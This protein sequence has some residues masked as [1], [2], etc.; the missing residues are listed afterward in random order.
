MLICQKCGT[1]N[2]LGRVFCQSCGGKLDLSHMSQD[3][4]VEVMQDKSW[5]ARHWRKIA[6][7]VG[8]LVALLVVLA[9]I[10]TAG[11]LGES[12]TRVGGRRV[13][14]LLRQLGGLRSGQAV[15]ATFDE[16]DVNGYLALV[17]ADRLKDVGRASVDI[18]PGYARLHLQSEWFSFSLF[19]FEL[20]PPKTYE[21]TLVPAGAGCVGVVKARMGRLPLSGPFRRSLVRRLHR[22]MVQENDW[23]GLA[24]LAEVEMGNDQIKVVARG[25]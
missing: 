9:M 1:D 11:P 15:S 16:K 14:S 19:G 6:L 20:K 22:R 13:E 10:P 3:V 4:I 23:K 18:Q 21:L 17:K 5:F 7:G 12:G 24:F 2:P 8:L 25:R